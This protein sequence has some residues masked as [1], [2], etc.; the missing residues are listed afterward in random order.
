MI[1]TKI[2]AI[3]K[4][5]FEYVLLT[6][7]FLKSSAMVK[8]ERTILLKKN[9]QFSANS[10]AL[11][12]LS[13]NQWLHALLLLMCIYRILNWWKSS[14]APTVWRILLLMFSLSSISTANK[15]KVQVW[16]WCSKINS[17]SKFNL[18]WIRITKLS[19]ISKC[20]WCHNNGIHI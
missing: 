6:H 11:F 5:S 1:T 10:C 20:L 9:F 15:D 13:S 2:Y 7:V 17:H 8:T 18:M 19:T 16:T 12:I 4:V 14:S 3:F